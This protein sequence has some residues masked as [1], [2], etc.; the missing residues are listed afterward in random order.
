MSKL[1]EIAEIARERRAIFLYT[2]FEVGPSDELRPLP[3]C[4]YDLASLLSTRAWCGLRAG[5]LDLAV[6]GGCV[7]CSAGIRNPVVHGSQCLQ[8]LGR[9]SSEYH[10]HC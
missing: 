1:M 4:G 10:Y 6:R 8:G 3:H 5:L 9:V 2:E 7:S